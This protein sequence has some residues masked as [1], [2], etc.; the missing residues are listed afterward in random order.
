MSG[1]CNL[2]RLCLVLII[3]AIAGRAA[4]LEPGQVLIVA[5]SKIPNSVAMAEYYAKARGI[6][7][8]NIVLIKTTGG[9]QVSRS[10]YDDQIRFPVQRALLERNLAPKIRCIVLLWGVPVRVAAP[11]IKPAS[12]PTTTTTTG[13]VTVNTLYRSTAKKTHY[14]L[15]M[16]YQLL[17]TIGKNFPQPQTADLKPLG[18]LFGEPLP[19]IPTKLPPLSNLK[20]DIRRLL[21]SK[22]VRVPHIGDPKKRGIAMRQVMAM[23]LEIY[24][25]EGLVSY[26]SESGIKKD[27]PYFQN[28]KNQ[29]E[30]AKQQLDQLS[31]EKPSADNVKTRLAVMEKANGLLHVC[32]YAQGK[33]K[34]IK[35]SKTPLSK[36]SDAS[37]DSE[38]AMIWW[39][40]YK[41][42]GPWRNALHWQT[43]KSL[44]GKR[45]PRTIMTARIDGPTHIDAM[46]IINDSLAAE[47]KP[48]LGKFYIDA[49]GL[50]S[51]YDVHL[52]NL[53]R[54]ITTKTDIVSVLD[55]EKTLFQPGQCPNA[56]MYVGWY[57]LRQYIPAFKWVPGAVG[58]HIASFE[59]MALRTPTSNQWCP[60]MIQNGV[61]ATI[62]AVN[63]PT[64][65]AFPLPEE[66]FPLLLTGKYTLA[67]CYWRTN[68]YTSWRM[69]LIGDPLYTPFATKARANIKDLPAGLAP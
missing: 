11:K 36:A 19:K 27:S 65:Q 3:A 7:K 21:A 33:A 66:F 15:V 39:G 41:L 59:A 63:E 68:P 42:P 8:E 55:R 46:R 23:Y 17:A 48:P 64:L 32:T 56:A 22:R 18:K 34:P 2:R 28:L 50:H 6:G 16:D 5:N 51:Q 69:T 45:V 43:A 13:A 67:E 12:V 9:Y 31:A 49:G 24:G 1:E 61:T 40:N 38:L 58:W 14:R 52:M 4:G 57:S 47:K 37:V 10:A 26:L 20:N 60:K 29:L 62:G 25:L 54:F 30:Q 44:V 53:H 35:K